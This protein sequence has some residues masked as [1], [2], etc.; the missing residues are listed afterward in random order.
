MS[1]APPIGEES[2]VFAHQVRALR[3]RQR[4]EDDEAIGGF[5]KRAGFRAHVDDRDTRPSQGRSGGS[6][7][8]RVDFH[9]ASPLTRRDRQTGGA[10][11]PHFD[12]KAVVAIH[13]PSRNGVAHPRCGGGGM[14]AAAHF[15]YVTDG[16][17]IGLATHIDYIRRETGVADPAGE[18]LLDMLDE[19][20]MRAELNQLACYTNI[21]GGW[22]RAR[23]LFDAAERAA[24]PPKSHLLQASTA[25]LADFETQLRFGVPAWFREMTRRLRAEADKVEQEADKRGNPVRHR[26]VTIA[27]VSNDEAYDRLDWFEHRPFAG[28]LVTWK[29]GRTQRSQHRFVGELPDGL[30][31]IDRHEILS[32]FCGT[33]A[34]DGWMVIGAIHQPDR[35]NDRRNF[36]LH[37]DGLDRPAEWLDEHGCWDFEYV[38][39]RNGKDTHPY[40]QNKVRYDVPP[41]GVLRERFITIV[42]EV[43]GDR[44]DVVRYLHGTYAD[45][46]IGLTPLDHMGNRAI[47][48]ESRGIETEVGSRNARRI[49]AD[50]AA[51]CEKRA[52]EAEAALASELALIRTIVANDLAA[53]A[54]VDHY[55]RLERRLIRRRLQRELADVV[56]TMARSR[57]ETVVHTLTPTPGRPVTPREGDAE[58]LAGAQAHLGWVERNSP[59][60][61]DREAARR[62]EEAL[63]ARATDQWA[64]VQSATARLGQAPAKGAVV[65]VPRH[66]APAAAIAAS[67]FDGQKRDRLHAWLRKHAGDGDLLIFETGEARLGR[68]V[69]KAIDTLM[70]QFAHEPRFQRLLLAERQRR[71][72]RV[73]M[74]GVGSP[75]VTRPHQATG[76][77][78]LRPP[79]AAVQSLPVPESNTTMSAPTVS[80]P[81]SARPA[82]AA[83]PTSVLRAHLAARQAGKPDG[84]MR[85]PSGQARSEDMEP[86][87]A[88]TQKT[89]AT[90]TAPSP[91]IPTDRSNGGLLAQASALP[92]AKGKEVVAKGPAIPKPT[93]SKQKRPER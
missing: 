14:G 34:E 20:E 68:A 87:G 35:H 56:I 60:P 46:G 66:H 51:A 71:A 1:T 18:L 16:A 3:A 92:L 75:T 25:Q 30:S 31:A 89:A 82:P 53:I 38:E 8:D 24:P 26:T 19:Q 67:Q 74:G 52:N 43:V 40:R 7:P 33:L 55:E 45:N 21:P 70:R 72:D 37:V 69:P 13:P 80:P 57:A 36:H 81:A 12:V 32:R 23:N 65:Y 54:A 78:S 9:A 91:A 86:T 10:R 28:D 29:Q 22:D 88:S 58:L 77:I 90:D 11:V 2:E 44:A 59:T 4:R 73:K 5:L 50:E 85:E 76:A 62:V 47:G 83:L 42:N 63:A 6:A 84:G 27:E 48:L 49:F 64:I 61:E 39:R 41:A 15:D 79:G 93:V 17:R